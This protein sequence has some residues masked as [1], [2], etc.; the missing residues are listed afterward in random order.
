M[1]S[2]EGLAALSVP[3]DLSKEACNQVGQTLLPLTA[4]A[5]ALY[6]KT[7]NYHWHMSGTHFKAYHELLD[8][9]GDQLFAMVDQLAER[10]RKL[11]QTTLR[12]VGQIASLTRVADD[13]RDFVDPFT[14]LRQLLDDNKAYGTHMRDAHGIIDA[15][16]DV[17]TTSLLENFIDE[18]ERRI[19][20][21]YETVPDSY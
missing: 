20:F 12:S 18:T 4:D 6:I 1:T 9:H 16:G 7:K 17:A 19:W 10:A 15:A 8:E 11:G 2:N 21:L 14:M 13:D 5:I 3:S